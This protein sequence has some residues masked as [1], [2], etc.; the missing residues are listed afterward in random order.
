MAAHLIDLEGKNTLDRALVFHGQTYLPGT[1]IESEIKSNWYEVAY[2]FHIPLGQSKSTTTRPDYQ[3]SFCWDR[4][5]VAPTVA[6]AFWDFSTQIQQSGVTNERGYSKVTPRLGMLLEWNP[7][8]KFALIGDAIGSIPLNNEAHIYTLGLTAKYN[9]IQKNWFNLDLMMGAEYDHID[10]EDSQTF[11]N[12]V[13][14]DMGP[15]LT[16]GLQIRF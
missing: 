13:R 4:L 5:I 2:R 7:L 6:M 11:P 12:K 3:T 16:G 1:R 8:P 15:M 9:L 14:I 10:F